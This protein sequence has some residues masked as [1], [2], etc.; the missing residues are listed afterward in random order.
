MSDS[1]EVLRARKVAREE[2]RV[3]AALKREEEELILEEELEK[4]LAGPRGIAFDIINT[5]VGLFA[6][7]KPEFVVAKRF[8]SIPA[9]KRHDEEVI[10]FVTPCVVFPDAAAFRMVIQEHGGIAWRC[11]LSLLSMYEAKVTERLGK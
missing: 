1:L 5:E 11:A 8:N 7:R 4:K 6:V 2:M 3:A 10:Q 9:E